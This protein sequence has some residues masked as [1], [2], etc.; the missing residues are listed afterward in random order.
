[1]TRGP[2]ISVVAQ[3][4]IARA[5]DWSFEHFGD[6]AEARYAT[7]IAAAI[8]HAAASRHRPGFKQRD[9]LGHGVLSW[10]LSQSVLR[11]PGGQV[12]HPRHVLLCR[13][14]DDRL[15]IARMLHDAQDPTLHFDPSTDWT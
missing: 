7:L 11:A 3:R 12:K 8:D 2:R 4:D 1:M 15:E 10:H 13:W 9:E 14:N 6:A 5:L